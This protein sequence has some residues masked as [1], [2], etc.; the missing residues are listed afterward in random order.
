[1]RFNTNLEVAK[2]HSAVLATVKCCL[3]SL[4]IS[5]CSDTRVIFALCVTVLKHELNAGILV[6]VA[7][8]G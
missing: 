1:M 2:H 7:K 4:E 5:D 3:A 6:I 8:L